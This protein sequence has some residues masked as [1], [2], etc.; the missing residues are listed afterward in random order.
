VLQV[1]GF[2]ILRL[3]PA[4][5]ITPMRFSSPNDAIWLGS[6]LGVAGSQDEGKRMEKGD[7]GYVVSTNLRNYN[8]R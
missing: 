1:L 3:S 4:L 8:Q 7:M 2:S 5:S 6:L